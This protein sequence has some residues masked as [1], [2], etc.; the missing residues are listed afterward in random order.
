[1]VLPADA[2][3]IAKRREESEERPGRRGGE[4]R[5]GRERE[6][7]RER[8]ERASNVVRSAYYKALRNLP[9]SLIGR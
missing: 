9:S 6:R 8:G 3:V 2:G 1:M 7:E 5:R 4:I